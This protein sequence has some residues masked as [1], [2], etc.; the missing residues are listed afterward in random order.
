MSLA[1]SFSSLHLLFSKCPIG[2]LHRSVTVSKNGKVSSKSV[3]NYKPY[4]TTKNT[5]LSSLNNCNSPSYIFE[6]LLYISFHGGAKPLFSL[7]AKAKE[8]VP[9]K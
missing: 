8:H 1:P 6:H 3:P 7:P 4:Y 5:F 9:L 2:C